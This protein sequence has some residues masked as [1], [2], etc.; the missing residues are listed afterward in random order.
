MTDTTTTA[1]APTTPAEAAPDARPATTVPISDQVVAQIN[2]Q[3]QGARTLRDGT[4]HAV[5]RLSPEHLGEITITLDVR[6]GGVRL[7][8]GGGAQAITALQADLGR[9]RDDLAG[10]GLNLGDVTLHSQD[11]P[12]GQAFARDGGRGGSSSGSPEPGPAP[13][14]G[15]DRTGPPAVPGRR[16][17]GGLDLL[18]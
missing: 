14:P 18:V 1:A 11:A 16:S 3:L 12:G 17:D 13:A 2:R 4:H 5:L 10:S 6:A 8:I 15:V 7:D 9:L